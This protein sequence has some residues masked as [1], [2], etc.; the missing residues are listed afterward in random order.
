MES[1]RGESEELGEANPPLYG[2]LLREIISHVP[3]LHLLSAVHVSRSWRLAVSLSLRDDPSRAKPWLVLHFQSP[4]DPSRHRA[5]AYDPHSRAWLHLHPRVPPRV[6]L[7]ASH[8]PLLFQLTPSRLSVS[9][10]ALASSWSDLGAPRVWRSD[11]VVASFGGG[12][13]VVAGGA[14]G[15]EGEPLAVEVRDPISRAWTPAPPVPEEFKGSDSATWLSVAV[16]GDSMHVHERMSGLSCS[17]DPA[18]KIWEKPF[19]MRPDPSIFYSEIV[20]DGE[21]LI[22]VGI[23]GEPERVNGLRIWRVNREASDLDLMGEMPKEMVESLKAEDESLP[24]IGV[25]STGGIAYVYN[26]TRPI[27]IFFCDFSNGGRV[28]EWGRVVKMDG[29]DSMDRIV[30]SCSTVGIDDL[31]RVNAYY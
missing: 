29:W 12:C 15:F 19:R 10:D 28:T 9:A 30:V 1:R 22:V 21:D 13:A 27:E 31:R 14:C 11:P 5:R 16:A 6:P 25:A 2:D 18:A 23:S 26:P 20:S 24:S 8:S 17:F 7:R 4:R 3:L